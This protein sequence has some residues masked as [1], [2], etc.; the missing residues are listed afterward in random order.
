[1]S[2]ISEPFYYCHIMSDV[3]FI[4]IW[5]VWD[6]K[7]AHTTKSKCHGDVM[8]EDNNFMVFQGF[9]NQFALIS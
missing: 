4:K 5:V 1:M 8:S 7:V 3:F 6:Q 9:F 2:K